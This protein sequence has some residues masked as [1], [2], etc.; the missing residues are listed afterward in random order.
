MSKVNPNT[1]NI[2]IGMLRQWLNEER[3]KDAKYFVTNED[4]H[5]WLDVGV[6]DYITSHLRS[7]ELPAERKPDNVSGKDYHNGFNAAIR[8]IHSI[9][10]AKIKEIENNEPIKTN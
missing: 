8:E 5:D 2:R 10:N 1:L 9:I 6:K 7:I 3:I 4:I